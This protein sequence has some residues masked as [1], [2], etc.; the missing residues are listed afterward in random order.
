MHHSLPLDPTFSDAIA[1]TGLRLGLVDPGDEVAGAAWVRADLRGFHADDVEHS[2]AVDQLRAFAERRMTGV[3]DDGAATPDIPV[4][5]VSSWVTSLSLPG[6][7]APGSASID[8]WAISSV[9]VSPTHRRRGVARALLEGELRTAV[10]GGLPLAALTVSEA[11][12]YRR[13]G[14]ACAALAADLAIDTRRAKWTGPTARGRV[15]FVER[16]ALRAQ[17]DDIE[18]RAR[19]GIPGEV[20]RWD[21]RWDSFFGLTPETKKELEGLRS[22]RYDDEHGVAQGFAL[23]K[24]K[25]DD[26]DYSAHTVTVT[27]FVA[28]TDDAYAGLWRFLL[29]LDLVTE[30]RA[31]LRSVD[32]PL[33]WMIADARALRTTA[34]SDHLW[35]RVLDVVATL[36]ARH[37]SAPGS[38][39]FDVTDELGYA[40]GRYVLTV[41]PDGVG[42]VV[43]SDDA[44]AEASVALDVAEL[45]ALLLG[46]ISAVTLRAAGRIH[47]TTDA[48]T[49]VDRIFHSPVPPR[50]GIWF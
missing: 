27:E 28:V 37:Y 11:T 2:D 50:L 39:A 46:G 43:R 38:V 14:F 5:T 45:G 19:R 32:E 20:D 44:A 22:V 3:Y 24:L 30:V 36:S 6:A 48:A 17:V 47:T 9:T 12:I 4:A 34:I 26:H 41:G 15:Q 40:G 10:A 25:A 49:L 31:S 35:L 29:E 33:R 7:D 8:A 13:F 21:R 42:A 16:A 23:Y 1:A 18:R